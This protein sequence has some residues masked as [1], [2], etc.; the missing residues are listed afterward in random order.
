M[1]EERLLQDYLND[2]L[3][4]I[5]DI[6][7]FTKELTPESSIVKKLEVISMQFSGITHCCLKIFSSSPLLQKKPSPCE[8]HHIH[9]P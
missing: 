3:E 1:S 4:S 6:R 2:I 7:E 9:N 5:A 8:L